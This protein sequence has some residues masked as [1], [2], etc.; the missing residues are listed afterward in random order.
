[1]VQ[2]RFFFD[3]FFFFKFFFSLFSNCQAWN[4]VILPNFISK[5]G[6]ESAK[7][8]ANFARELVKKNAVAP[9]KPVERVEPVTSSPA[10]ELKVNVEHKN[11]LMSMGYSGDQ[12][13]EALIVANGNVD[14]ALNYLLDS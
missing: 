12:A 11:T 13:T 9:P 5:P 14:A 4:E 2:K 1:M 8:V 3:F 7:E 6:P 10:P